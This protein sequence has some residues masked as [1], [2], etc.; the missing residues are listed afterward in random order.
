VCAICIYPLSIRQIEK[1]NHL[2]L[3]N[4]NFFV[5]GLCSHPLFEGDGDP[6][7]P[8]H[9]LDIPSL[10]AI[11]LTPELKK[12][13]NIWPYNHKKRKIYMKKEPKDFKP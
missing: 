4:I 6:N 10:L 8:F 11:S 9:N 12:T 1:A 3:F 13:I 7:F 5:A 2:N